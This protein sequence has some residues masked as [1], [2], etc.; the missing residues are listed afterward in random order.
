MY[1]HCRIFVNIKRE[2]LH[3]LLPLNTPLVLYLEPS[4]LCNFKCK[5]CPQYLDPDALIKDMMGLETYLKVIQDIEEFPQN[6]KVLRFIGTGEP[7][8]N[9]DLPIFAQIARKSRKIERIELTS[10]A[11]LFNSQIANA[12][13]PYLDKII[14]SIEGLNDESYLEFAGTAIKF[15]KI[16]DNVRQLYESSGQCEIYVKIHSS[17]IRNQSDK[18][19]F[20]DTFLPVSDK[21]FIENL[22]N[23]WPETESKLSSKSNARYG[24]G[25]ISK[26][27]CAQ[28]FKSMMIN[29]NGDI[30]PCC[31]DFKRKLMIGNVMS[32]SLL[33]IWKSDSLRELRL[34]HLCFNKDK[35]SVCKDCSYND[36]SDVDYLDPYVDEI[37]NRFKLVSH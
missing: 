24:G 12:I 16:V 7:L 13:C 35:I 17:A 26:K 30:V 28:I 15:N 6:L 9:K 20:L 18:D 29:A 10:N 25:V 3:S 33:S 21:A 37:L 11:S 19:L 34:K 2:Q 1:G 14:I 27:V 31:V 8:L 5:F 22:V 36:Y 23:L 32:Q 4:G